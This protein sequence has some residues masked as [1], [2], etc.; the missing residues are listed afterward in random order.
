MAIQSDLIKKS[1]TFF[2]YGDLSLGQGKAKVVS[3]LKD[4]KDLYKEIKTKVAS[5]YT[6]KEFIPENDD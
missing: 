1:G 6:P 2:S 4:D 5:S 3:L